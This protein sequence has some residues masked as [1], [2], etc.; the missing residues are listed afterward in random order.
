MSERCSKYTVQGPFTRR[1]WA[2]P[3]KI[4]RP[5]TMEVSTMHATCGGRDRRL[6]LLRVI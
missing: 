6:V 2:T 5:K 3:H 1:Y 4:S